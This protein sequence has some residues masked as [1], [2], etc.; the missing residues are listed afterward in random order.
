[1]RI[2]TSLVADVYGSHEECLLLRGIRIKKELE[3]N[4]IIEDNIS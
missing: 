1:M 2:A 4:D 3:K